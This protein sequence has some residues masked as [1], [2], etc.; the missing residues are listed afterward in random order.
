MPI[1]PLRAAYAPE[2]WDSQELP[3]TPGSEVKGVRLRVG[4]LRVLRRGFLY[5]LLD[6]REWQ[7]YQVSPEGMLR[8][9]RPFEMP[10]EQPQPLNRVCIKAD[11]DIPASFLNIDT[12]KYTTAWLAFANDPWP[13]SVLNR[14]KRGGVV[15]GMS[16]EER[17][18]KLDLKAARNDP[19]SV[20]IA[21]TENNLQMEQVLE[22]SLIHI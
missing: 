9:I 16:L 22:L 1:L 15:D 13:A 17:F 6:R 5:V 10:R 21:M 2:P 4:Q 3:L 14:Y 8:Q 12:K 11:H 7:A 20:G 18:H 19:A